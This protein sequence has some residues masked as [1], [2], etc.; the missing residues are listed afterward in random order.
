MINPQSWLKDALSLLPVAR[1]SQI[2]LQS[3]SSYQ[4]AL[5]NAWKYNIQRYPSTLISV[6]IIMNYAQYGGNFS[7][8]SRF[9][10]EWNYC[11]K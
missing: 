9:R 10:L 1:L 7:Y 11:L 2:L 5:C 4:L 8:A 3:S 6:I